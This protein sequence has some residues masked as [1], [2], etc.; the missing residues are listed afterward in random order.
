MQQRKA[1]GKGLGLTA[2]VPPVEPPKGDIREIEIGKIIPNRYQPRQYFDPE[3]LAALAAS[4]KSH[5]LIQPI[6][7]RKEE[8]G[9]FELIAGERRWRAAQLAGLAAIPAIVKPVQDQELM[10][11]ALLEN[12]QRED[13]NPI[14]KAQAYQR[15]ISEFSLTQE[16]IAARMGIDRSSVAN[17]LRLLLLPESLWGSIADGVL[18][19]GHAKALLSLERKEDQLRIAGEI[20]A[21]GWSVRQV[22]AL[23]QKMKREARPE[24][25]KAP[26]S[27]APETAELESRLRLALGTKVRL[28]QQG[29]GGEIRI[30][31]Y[32]FEDLDRILEKLTGT[33]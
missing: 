19:M 13:L 18:T 31:Y 11:W 4:L 10:E 32:S 16:A 3:A 7:V 23:V 17:F 21:K 24:P 14:E 28:V 5:G 2:L 9:R 8:N 25:P 27:A 6:T 29:K 15:L 30:E 22:E 20:K 33:N 26:R 12:V 1:L